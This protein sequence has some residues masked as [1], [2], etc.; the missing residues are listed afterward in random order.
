MFRGHG[1]HDKC[2]MYIH[3][4]ARAR[5]DLQQF[6]RSNDT[7]HAPFE[8]KDAGSMLHRFKT[9]GLLLAFVSPA[10]HRVPW[11]PASRAAGG[12]RGSSGEHLEQQDA[13]IADPEGPVAP[14]NS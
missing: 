12:K 13:L 2:H 11:F 1:V 5:L 14:L 7:L 9:M 6:R 3:V 10:V 8:E 4:R